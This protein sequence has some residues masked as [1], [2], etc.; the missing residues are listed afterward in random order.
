MTCL[1]QLWALSDQECRVART[2][3]PVAEGTVL[4]DRIVFPQEG[5]AFFRMAGIAIVVNRVLL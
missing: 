1:A 5:A 4:Y 2:V 3:Y